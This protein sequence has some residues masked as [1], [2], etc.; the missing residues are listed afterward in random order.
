M[1]CLYPKLLKRYGKLNK[2]CVNPHNRYYLRS[3]L[4][5]AGIVT[6]ILHMEVSKG[7]SS[8]SAKSILG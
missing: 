7:S 8:L 6:F 5:K 2:I 4:S 3:V 1:L